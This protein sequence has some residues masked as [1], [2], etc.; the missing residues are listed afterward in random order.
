MFPSDPSFHPADFFTD[1][2]YAVQ[3][4]YDEALKLVQG[5]ARYFELPADGI[6]LIEVSDG[7]F[8]RTRDA[9]WVRA[10]DT[11]T[12]EN[13]Q[14]WARPITERQWTDMTTRHRAPLRSFGDERLARWKVGF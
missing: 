5:A 13:G 2:S 6:L 1:S 7:V 11:L 3:L 8:A 9:D 14:P 4:Q 10:L 12:G